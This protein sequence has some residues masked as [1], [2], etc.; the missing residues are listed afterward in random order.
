M[1]KSKKT[2][3]TT[4][5]LVENTA[6][7]A[8]LVRSIAPDPTSLIETVTAE[9]LKGI[10][11]ERVVSLDAGQMLRGIYLGTGPNVELTDTVTGEVR[12]LATHRIEV[13]PGMIARVIESYQLARELPPLKGQRVRVI[14]LNQVSTRKGRRVNEWVVAPERA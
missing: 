9:S 3:G 8:E 11:L 6:V 5:A 13:R 1:A 7:G 4:T 2:N 12:E 14:R 10:D